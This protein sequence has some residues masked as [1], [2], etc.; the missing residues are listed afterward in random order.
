MLIEGHYLAELEIH[1]PMK[2][3]NPFEP[4]QDT[5]ILWIL[6]MGRILVQ[7]NSNCNKVERLSVWGI[8]AYND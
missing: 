7:S 5:V 3:S 6:G 1:K 2:K 4:K 8:L